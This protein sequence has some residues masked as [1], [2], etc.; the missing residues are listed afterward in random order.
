MSVRKRPLPSGNET[1]EYCI[2]L[3]RDATGKRLQEKRSGFATKKEA[4]EAKRQREN[5]I[6]ES[7]INLKKLAFTHACE[8]YMV[9]ARLHYA[10]N[11]LD[12]YERYVKDY[13]EI[14]KS[15]IFS[16]I[17]VAQV[18]DWKNYLLGKNKPA[19]T[20][21]DCIKL[22]KAI[23]NFLLENQYINRNPFEYVKKLPVKQKEVKVF[24]LRQIERLLRRAKKD[25][26]RL[27]PL[28]YTAIFTGMRQGELLGL[29]WC[30]IDFTNRKL[31]VRRQYT[32]G[33][34]TET[35]KTV[36]SRRCI[37]LSEGVVTCL[38]EYRA[39]LLTNH[40][41]VFCTNIGTPLQ[42]E[43]VRR[44]WY[45]PLLKSFKWYG[46]RWHDTRHTYASLMLSQGISYLYVSKQMGH[47]KPTVTLDVYGHFIPD[48]NDYAID[49]IDDK[50]KKT[51][52]D[53]EQRI[54]DR[55]SE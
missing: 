23:G 22:L 29:K 18:N 37:D 34:M 48:V 24:N 53:K 41:L 9:N 7:K 19:S 54:K 4:L 30:D 26:P 50:F 39:T 13:F 28:L 8:L 55:L 17:Q 21:N 6:F 11:T 51:L 12:K 2:E 3:G 45:Y 31:Y 43:N 47:S 46:Y 27:Y 15:S 32:N 38:K 5:E 40:E 35:L 44:R 33:V 25:Y 10:N 36:K 20:I 49:I 42:N 16:A 52:A 14:F 1:W